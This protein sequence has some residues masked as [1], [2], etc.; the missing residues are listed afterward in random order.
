MWIKITNHFRF[1]EI[2][3]RAKNIWIFLYKLYQ[4]EPLKL[5]TRS[6]VNCCYFLLNCSF[7]L[8][9][10]DGYFWIIISRPSGWTHIVLNYI[11]PENGQGIQ[12]YVDG[13]PTESAASKTSRPSQCGNGRVVVGRLLTDRDHIKDYADVDVDELLFFNEKLSDQQVIDIK[14]II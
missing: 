14:N 3:E 6:F 5:V 4:E 11:G 13:L 10:L 7:D 9:L 12:I 1:E 2:V 8:R